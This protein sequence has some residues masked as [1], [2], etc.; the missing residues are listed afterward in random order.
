MPTAA[1][2]NPGAML[3]PGEAAAAALDTAF[4]SA[5]TLPASETA[6][7]SSVDTS[8]AVAG[9]FG[10]MSAALVAAI[11]VL[12]VALAALYLLVIR[13]RRKSL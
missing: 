8:P 12:V 9:A 4:A 2:T 7:A 13:P 10:T 1:T 3:L 5:Y 6:L 11:A